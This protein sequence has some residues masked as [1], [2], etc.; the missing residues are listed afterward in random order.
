[1]KD[2][3]IFYMTHNHRH[4]SFTKFMDEL[5]DMNFDRERITLL[6]VN[7][8]DDFSFYD[9][10]MNDYDIHHVFASVPCPSHDYLPKVRYAIQY[11]K[12]N[13]YEYIFKCDNDVILPSYTLEYMFNNIEKI[14]G[15]K[16]LSM[17]PTLTSGIPSVEYFLD[18]FLSEEEAKEVRKEFKKCVFQVQPGV[19]D[20]RPLNVCSV[21]TPEEDWDYEKYYKTLNDYMDSLPD[22]G[23]GR[24]NA[25]NKFYKGI[26]PVRHGFGIDLINDYIIKYKDRFFETKECSLIRDENPYLCD[27]CFIIRTE[28][29][30]VLLNKS[31]LVID[32]CDEVPLNRY[33]WDTGM[34]HLIVRNGFAI[35]MVYNWMFHQNNVLGGSNIDQ[36]KVSM[37]EYED[38]FLS[39]LYGVTV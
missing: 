15:Q 5:C 4:P 30:D 16:N 33:A 39:K 10:V 36:P 35:H 25:G 1:M 19:M 2:I 9:E 29:Y 11:A 13:N 20:Y 21:D 37:D 23:N 38:I 17:S 26:H 8:S 18:D 27:M 28:S 3:L 31:G 7:T 14:D 12:E 32:G 22:Y 6:V 24:T 34:K